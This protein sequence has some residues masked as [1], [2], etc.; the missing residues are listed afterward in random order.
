MA[1]ITISRQRGSK[2]SYIA[3]EVARRMGL[4]YLDREILD[5][6]AHQAGVEVAELEAIEAHAGRLPRILHLLGARP[7]LPTVASAS[8]REQATYEA[9]IGKL[10]VQQGLDRDAAVAL[11]ESEGTPAYQPSQDYLELTKTVILEYAQQGDA[12]IVGRGAQMILRRRPGVLHVQVVGKFEN[13]V[14]NIIERE[15]VKWREAAHRLRQAD[16]ERAGYLRR[17]YGVDW[18]DPGL[19]DVVLNTDQIPD[20]TAVEMIILAAN[21][22]DQA[23]TASAPSA[24]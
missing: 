1:V 12:V 23:A 4:R 13:R 20:Q 16:E 18:L 15:G 6:V 11:L 22:V 2:G 3:L 24:G 14:H 17:F 7:R 21:A 10:M 5:S 19:Y 9:R 8:L